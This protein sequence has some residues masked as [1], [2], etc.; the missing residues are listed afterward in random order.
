MTMLKKTKQ[1]KKKKVQVE[2]E[3]QRDAEETGDLG[4]VEGEGKKR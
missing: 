2:E 1:E 3:E 4:V